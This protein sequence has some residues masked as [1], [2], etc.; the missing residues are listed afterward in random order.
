MANLY[1]FRTH[2]TTG[3]SLKSFGVKPSEEAGQFPVRS[4]CRCGW[5]SDYFSLT[6]CKLPS[7]QE[8]RLRGSDHHAYQSIGLDGVGSSGASTLPSRISATE[9][10]KVLILQR[11]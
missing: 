6:L 1:N 4:K 11:P 2:L 10:K 7:R 9:K 8:A 5:F 3:T